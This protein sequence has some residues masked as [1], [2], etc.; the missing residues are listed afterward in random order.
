[1]RVRVR[2]R[3]RERVTVWVDLRPIGLADVAVGARTRAGARAHQVA[4]CELN[5][6]VDLRARVRLEA[7]WLDAGRLGG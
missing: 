3:V 5:R 1:M 2:A 4:E 6:V 7:G